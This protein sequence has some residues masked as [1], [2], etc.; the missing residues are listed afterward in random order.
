MK[1]GLTKT[2]LIRAKIKNKSTRIIQHNVMKV[3]ATTIT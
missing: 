2:T 3:G 1:G